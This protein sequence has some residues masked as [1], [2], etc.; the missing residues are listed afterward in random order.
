MLYPGAQ[1]VLGYRLGVWRRLSLAQESFD[2]ECRILAIQA[3]KF[4]YLTIVPLGS[5][6]ASEPPTSFTYKFRAAPFG[7]LEIIL[8]DIIRLSAI[9]VRST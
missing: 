7:R 9:S 4:M 1:D 6:T 5:K 8:R 2:T 3:P